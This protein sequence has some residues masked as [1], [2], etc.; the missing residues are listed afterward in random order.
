[1]KHVTVIGLADGRESMLEC[2]QSEGVI[3]LTPCGPDPMPCHESADLKKQV[4]RR[5]S[6]LTM[7]DDFRH[8]RYELEYTDEELPEV[9][10]GLIDDWKKLHD[11]LYALRHEIAM[12]TPL[13]DFD[14]KGIEHLKELNVYVQLWSVP[15]K[16]YELLEF[17]EGVYHKVLDQHTDLRFCTV[18]HGGPVDMDAPAMEI[19]PPAKSVTEMRRAEDAFEKRVSEMTE[20]FHQI[21]SRRRVMVDA[22]NDLKSQLAFAIG[23]EGSYSDGQFFGLEGWAPATRAAAVKKCLCSDKRPVYIAFRDPRDDE[24][25]PVQTHE[26]AWARPSRAL[27]NVLGVTP[28]YREFDISPIFIIAMAIFTAML[29]G[30]AGYGLLIFIPLALFYRKIRYKLGFDKD[31][32]HLMMILSGSIAVYGLITMT[33]FGWTPSNERFVL[34]NS[35]DDILMQRLCFVIGAIHLTAAHLW[36]AYRKFK[37]PVPVKALADV[38]WVI[39]LWAMYM[40]VMFLVIGDPLPKAFKPMLYTGLSMAVLFNSPQKNVLKMVGLGL[41]DIPLNILSCFSDI[42]SYV[43]LMAVGSAGVV[44]EVAFNELAMG[45]KHPVFTP[46]ILIVAHTLVMALGGV[47]ILAHG[48]RLNMLEFSGHMDIMWSGRK[49]E[50]FC[51]YTRKETTT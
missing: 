10:C 1:M 13:G 48:V 32:L 25:P 8:K 6:C 42:I 34:L 51:T 38:G 29:I 12:Y 35:Y 22:L 9:L 30:D 14:P 41:A 4:A 3:H 28:G 44:M 50:P 39:V 43:R 31:M 26:P 17:D 24:E 2:L 7:L 46:L 49:Y 36:R 5:Q 23:Q 19:A 18:S 27:F 45:L 37:E 40:L 33:V 20:V 11:D 16:D 21:S 47:A 15:Q